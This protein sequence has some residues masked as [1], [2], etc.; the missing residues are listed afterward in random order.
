MYRQ[1]STFVGT[2]LYFTCI[3]G[4]RIEFEL[5]ADWLAPTANRCSPLDVD[6]VCFFEICTVNLLMFAELRI[7][8]SG[9]LSGTTLLSRD[10]NHYLK[11]LTALGKTDEVLSIFT[12]NFK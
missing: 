5:G 3:Y 12:P 6:P 9:N 2:K 11:L 1:S 4:E 10:F 8:F 7:R